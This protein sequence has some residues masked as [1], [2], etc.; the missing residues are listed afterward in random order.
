MGVWHCLGAA[1]EWELVSVLIQPRREG[2]DNAKRPQYGVVL[3][4]C[5]MGCLILSY[6]LRQSWGRAVGPP[7]RVFGEIV[8]A[9]NSRSNSARGVEIAVSRLPRTVDWSRQ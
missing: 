7:R 9:P 2:Q 8:G 3:W 4:S 5:L 6:G 1:R